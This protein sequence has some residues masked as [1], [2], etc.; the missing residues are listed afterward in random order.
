MKKIIRPDGHEVT[1]S[2]RTLPCQVRTECELPLV[3]SFRH[4]EDVDAGP[5]P[6]LHTRKGKPSTL[7]VSRERLSH[8]RSTQRVRRLARREKN[9][10]D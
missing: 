7:C 4:P 10:N 1:S 3:A 5:A 8:E 6:E 9:D 2:L